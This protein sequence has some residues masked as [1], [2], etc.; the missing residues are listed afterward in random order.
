VSLVEA[1][2]RSTSPELTGRLAWVR[3]RALVDLQARQ[4]DW[5]AWTPRN[6]LRLERVRTLERE[7]PSASLP[8][9]N[10]L[11]KSPEH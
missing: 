4:A 9:S 11:T 5:R 10:P 7:R 1:E 2:R 8:A 6:A 3:E